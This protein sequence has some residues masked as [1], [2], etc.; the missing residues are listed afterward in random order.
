MMWALALSFY[1]MSDRCLTRC[2]RHRLDQE[3]CVELS[4]RPGAERDMA[5]RCPRCKCH[6]GWA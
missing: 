2:Y 6:C 3:H 5:K 4:V 1:L